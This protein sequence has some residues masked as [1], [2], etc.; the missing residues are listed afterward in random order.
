MSTELAIADYLDKPIVHPKDLDMPREQA[1]ELTKALIR[2]QELD[3]EALAPSS[4]EHLETKT[5]RALN[6][7]IT[8]L[9][10]DNAQLI[11]KMKEGD[12]FSEDGITPAQARQLFKENTKL[13]TELQTSLTK[14]KAA[15]QAN[16]GTS[17][18]IDLGGV[19]Q[20]ALSLARETE[21]MQ[22][23]TIDASV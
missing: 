18:S 12:M 13:L 14:S 5:S 19:F 22:A 11:K 1:R 17:L 21:A 10:E 3:E 23:K 4:V 7:A 8:A 20:E 16:G 2:E 15:N 9:E 6:E